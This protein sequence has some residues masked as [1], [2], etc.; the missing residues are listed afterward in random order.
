MNPE[1]EPDYYAMSL[2]E[3]IEIKGYK[4]RKELSEKI[5]LSERSLFAIEN[6]QQIPKIDTAA[7]ICRALNISFSQLCHSIGIDASDIPQE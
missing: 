5:G 4:S 7:K 6:R 1:Q 3:I 2:T